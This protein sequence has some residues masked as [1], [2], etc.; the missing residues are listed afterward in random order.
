MTIE[1]TLLTKYGALLTVSQLAEILS[2]SSEGIRISLRASTPWAEKINRARLKVGRRVYFR[3][4]EIAQF[5][6][7]ATA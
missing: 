6:H 1:E 5:L 3:T 2:R 7:D 4:A